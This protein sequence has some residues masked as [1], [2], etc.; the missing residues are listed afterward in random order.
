[1]KQ[2]LLSIFALSSLAMAAQARSTEV[3]DSS[4]LRDQA[5][6]GMVENH[7]NYLAVYTKGLVCSSCGIG[8]RIHS[9]KLEGV[10]KSQL[11]NGVDLDVKKQLVLVAFKPDAAIDVDGVR[12][13]IYNAGY[14]PVHYYIWTQMDG[15]VQT[16]YPVSEK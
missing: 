16:V 4:E 15:I 2:F 12:E 14:D 8:L 3:G 5:A 7:P 11:T 13:A 1:M 9:S 6:K 10:D